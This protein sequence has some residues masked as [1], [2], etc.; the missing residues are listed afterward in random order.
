MILSQ[1]G[2]VK[3][4]LLRDPSP[5]VPCSLGQDTGLQGWGPSLSSFKPCWAEYLTSVV[6][7]QRWADGLRGWG[8]QWKSGE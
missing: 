7:A 3:T 4:H 2:G 6:G 1:T 8:G 5:T